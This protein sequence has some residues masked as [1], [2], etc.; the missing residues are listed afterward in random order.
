MRVETGLSS[1]QVFQRNAQNGARI[2]CRGSCG[3]GLGSIEVRVTTVSS[4][5][6][7]WQPVGRAA[8]GK[9][10]ADLQ[11][12]TGGPYR[13]EL[14]LV[15]NGNPTEYACVEQVLVGDLWVLAGQSNM[16]GLGSL[17]GA[18]V[19]H[20]LVNS[21][22]MWDCWVNARD[23]LHELHRSVDPVHSA[24]E[25]REPWRGAGLG[26]PFAIE[27]VR[28][29]GVPIGLVPC[30]HGG[31]TLEQWDPARRAE[32]G[33]SLYGSLYRRCQVVGGRVKGLLWYQGC[34]DATRQV[35]SLYTKRLTHLI[36]AIRQDLES[37][38]L[39]VFVVQIG[40]VVGAGWDPSGWEKVR[41]AQRM[42]ASRVD[43]VYLTAAIDLDLEDNIH[44]NTD[45]LKRL[46]LRLAHQTCISLFSEPGEL[47]PVL[48]RIQV[49]SQ[50]AIRV[51][52]ERV[53]GGLVSIGRLAGFALADSQGNQLPLIHSQVIDGARGTSVLLRLIAALPRTALLLYGPGLDPYC[54]LRDE[55]GQAAAA[56]GPLP[57]PWPTGVA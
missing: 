54:N 35:A 36:A 52:Y 56:F 33:N 57:I 49:L 53:N 8:G 28:H 50:T 7:D 26:L 39:P 29:T 5:L 32:G 14:R 23:P 55:A 18:M 42:V 25:A 22:N 10:L 45:G 19:P 48:A 44:M 4:I 47:G 6:L 30:A 34:S 9:W 31:T 51:V 15:G 40:R 46:G 17:V 20:P 12:P 3:D 21:F 27:M 38:E 24:K 16:E 37:P 13:I 41:E 1:Y 43:G 2:T 11:L